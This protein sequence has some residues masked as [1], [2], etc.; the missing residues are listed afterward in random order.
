MIFLFMA[1]VLFMSC[2]KKIGLPGSPATSSQRPIE[3]ASRL[4]NRGNG[5]VLSL[6]NGTGVA[7]PPN[8][9]SQSATVSIEQRLKTDAPATGSR[10]DLA[11]YVYLF[12]SGP[13]IL[14]TA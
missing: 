11:G 5:G 7:I 13:A 12:D 6:S 8:V 14:T 9:L 2:S 1:A 3:T 10:M 4:I